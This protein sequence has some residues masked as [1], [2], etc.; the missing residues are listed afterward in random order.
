M[1]SKQSKRSKNS[2][3]D[4]ENVNAESNISELSPTQKENIRKQVAEQQ[5]REAPRNRIPSQNSLHK[6]EN[7]EPKLLS[8]RDPKRRPLQNR[9][10]FA[11]F[12]RG[13]PHAPTVTVSSGKLVPNDDHV[14]NALY[15]GYASINK[16]GLLQISKHPPRF[17]DITVGSAEKSSGVL[18]IF[19][20]TFNGGSMGMYLDP[21]EFGKGGVNATSQNGHDQMRVPRS[22]ISF[23]H[24]FGHGT[25]SDEKNKAESRSI[26]FNDTPPDHEKDEDLSPDLESNLKR[27]LRYKTL[28]NE[29]GER[30]VSVWDTWH[31]IFNFVS[32]FRE[33]HAENDIIRTLPP[34]KVKQK[35]RLSSAYNE[36]DYDFAIVL[37]AKEVYSFWAD[38]LDFRE[39]NGYRVKTHSD[40]LLSGTE[41]AEVNASLNRKKRRSDMIELDDASLISCDDSCLWDQYIDVKKRFSIGAV[42]PTRNLYRSKS[43]NDNG[44]FLFTKGKSLFDRAVEG[45]LYPT[46]N[47]NNDVTATSPIRSV[48]RKIRKSLNNRLSL[49][50]NKNKQEKK[51]TPS[52]ARRRW[53]NKYHGDESSL[54]AIMSPPIHSLPKSSPK[55]ATRPRMTY[56]SESNSG[57]ARKRMKK[58]ENVLEMDEIPNQTVPRGIK[59]RETGLKDFLW[60][61]RNGVVV[62]KIR[63]NHDPVYVRL[64]SLDGGDTIN[65]QYLFPED[66]VVA[67]RQQRQKYNKQ[68]LHGYGD[69]EQNDHGAWVPLDFDQGKHD[70]ISS[71][72]SRGSIGVR[73]S[74][75]ELVVKKMASGSFK[76]SELVA[77]QRATHPDPLTRINY[78][79]EETQKDEVEFLGDGTPTLRAYHER[80]SK[81]QEGN[82]DYLKV[83]NVRTFS[84]ILPSNLAFARGK[85]SLAQLNDKWLQNKASEKDFRFLDFEAA[86]NGEYWILFSGFLWL[87]RDAMNGRFDAQR[88][89]GFGA[90]AANKKIDFEQTDKSIDKPVSVIHEPIE[91]SYF[92]RLLSKVSKPPEETLVNLNIKPPPSDYFLGYTSEGTMIWGRLRNAGLDTERIYALDTKTVM[93]KIKCPE[94]RLMDVAEVLRLK[95]K[96]TQGYFAPFKEN[97]KDI[98]KPSDVSICSRNSLSAH[99][100]F[101]SAVTQHIIDF[102]INSR[103]RDS[104]AGLSGQTALDKSIAIRTPLHKH[105]KLEALCDLWV[106]FWREKNWINGPRMKSLLM[107][108]DKWAD[109]S[110]NGVQS[111]KRALKP[112]MSRLLMGCILSTFDREEGDYPVL[113]MRLLMGT[114]F[115]PLDS[116]EEYFGEKVTFYFAWLQHSS[117]HLIP[118]SILGLIVF[119]CQVLSG[120]FDHEVRPYYACVVMIWSFYVMCCWKKRQNFLIHR[121]GSLNHN[122]DESPRPQFYGDEKVDEATGEKIMHY[123]SWK[124][125]IKYMLSFPLTVAFTFSALIGLLMMHANRDLWLAR[126]FADSDKEHLF[127]INWSLSAIGNK[128]ALGAVELSKAHFQDPKFWYIVS[129]PPLILGLTLPLLNFILMQISRGLNDFE[130]HKTESQYRNALI[131]KV[132]AFRFVAYFA[133]L[134]YYAFIAT[135]PDQTTVEN[136]ILRVATSLVIYLTVANWWG[137][138]LGIYM[139]LL[140]LKWRKYRDRLKLRT[141][142]RTL[143]SLEQ[144]YT[145]D[146]NLTSEEAM[147]IEKS[148]INKRI[149][150]EQ[151]QSEVW[152]EM[153]YVSMFVI[154]HESSFIEN[155]FLILS[156]LFHVLYYSQASGIQSIF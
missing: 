84:I 78:Y 87:H 40:Y 48:A 136:G 97:E 150:I 128:E 54:R 118:I 49:N 41:K 59:A 26:R 146:K 90:G 93:I 120:K 65:Y 43:V 24:N 74:V 3:R 55:K 19:P 46:T 94:D 79:D 115:Q 141:E 152:Q 130:N 154:I 18:P 149:L 1:I 80:I 12:S 68:N 139:P 32:T 61:M 153:M 83:D 56:G 62:R 135:G 112:F 39:E 126:Y 104:G 122:Q 107:L 117:F 148:I 70:E 15:P 77:V 138:F 11:P 60:A 110:E 137:I 52:S 23:P 38:L 63:P 36:D 134:Y 6:T 2:S 86:T 53:G 69:E 9:S 113:F 123:P 129:L 73:K 103:I 132:I 20:I 35:A 143:Q 29:K 133:A 91:K 156:L 31:R 75:E 50:S 14:K 10:P 45:D 37:Q 114:F 100:L 119:L 82:T 111:E 4:K 72:E 109:N 145:K 85:A 121:W 28:K 47:N 140:I 131:A 21:N 151:A 88:N 108:D 127:D 27:V 66:A 76:A 34:N 17:V 5:S 30:I 116:I 25:Y 13:A 147:R 67:L 22:Y 125:W 7:N 92:A 105:A 57:S 142:L 16:N 106:F 89:K 99:N 96:T 8:V 101:S 144:T 95:M 51:T 81:I 155:L 58:N 44:Q 102:I 64:S 98:F 124:R 42:T 33:K 71:R